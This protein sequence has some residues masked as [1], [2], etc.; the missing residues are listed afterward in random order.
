VTSGASATAAYAAAGTHFTCFTSTITFSTN[1]DTCS[2]SL[3]DPPQKCWNIP[4]PPFFND[5][6]FR[7]FK[8]V[9][10][11]SF[12][13]GCVGVGVG[14]GVG[15]CVCVCV[16]VCMCVWVWV[17][18]W[19]GGRLCAGVGV[20]S[21]TKSCSGSTEVQKTDANTPGRC[22]CFRSTKSFGGFLSLVRTSARSRSRHS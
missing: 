17:G 13:C 21:T 3:T 20:V 6:A 14:V 2:H 12:V 19:V 16:Y 1:T 18:G 8:Q 9:S 15:V 5:I 7:L 22:R 11:F 10:V 4:E